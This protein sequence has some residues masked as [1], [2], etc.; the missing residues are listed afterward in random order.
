M[1]NLIFDRSL[2]L[3][4]WSS[5]GESWNAVSGPFYP[6][7]RPPGLYTVGRREITDYTA[8]IKPAFQDKTGRGF[9]IPIYPRFSTSRGKIG[10]R[11]GIH[12]DGNLPGTEGCIGLTGDNTRSFY[13]AIG[14]TATDAT[15]TLEVR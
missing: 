10:G 9:F 4:Y 15:I 5:T 7:Q 3:L 2:G 8:S 14:K 6:G 13:D 12:P 11:L 1:A